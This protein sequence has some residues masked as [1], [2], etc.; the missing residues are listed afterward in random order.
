M[1]RFSPEVIQALK[2]KLMTKK[3]AN[4]VLEAEEVA[5]LMAKTGL[6]EEQIRLWTKDLHLYYPTLEAKEKF[7]LDSKVILS[8][9]SL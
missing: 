6:T 5:D 1:P 9:Q 2:R 3:A 8:F 4:Y 7:L